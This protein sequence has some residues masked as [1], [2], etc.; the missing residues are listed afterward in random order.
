MS[1]KMVWSLRPNHTNCLEITNRH[2]RFKITFLIRHYNDI[3][4]YM[5]P[6][7]KIRARTAPQGVFNISPVNSSFSDCTTDGLW[8]RVTVLSYSCYRYRLSYNVPILR[9]INCGIRLRAQS[10]MTFLW[11]D[12][13]N[14]LRVTQKSKMHPQQA[15]LRVTGGLFV[16]YSAQLGIKTW[17][18]RSISKLYIPHKGVGRG[19]KICLK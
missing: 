13:V 10:W 11:K 3:V 8:C 7:V 4:L 9:L 2:N 14:W 5:V 17:H 19:N 6:P 1:V 12:W 18:G 15:C 16:D